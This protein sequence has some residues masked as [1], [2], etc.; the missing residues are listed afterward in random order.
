M[1]GETNF[2]HVD[3]Q[4][5]LQSAFEELRYLENP[6]V[7]LEVSFYGELASDLGGPRKEFFMLCLREIQSKYFDK[8][9]RDYMSEDY[10]VAGT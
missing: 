8:G 7:T 4:D 2:I 10:E 6:C 5:I 3:R 1:E 9:L